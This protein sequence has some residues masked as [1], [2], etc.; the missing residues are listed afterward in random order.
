MLNFDQDQY[1]DD[2]QV[3]NGNFTISSGANDSSAFF[4]M[5]PSDTNNN[6]KQSFGSNSFHSPH[7]TGG[8]G[9][10]S[11]FSNPSRNDQIVTPNAPPPTT[12]TNQGS[13]CSG[14]C[15]A[16]VWSFLCKKATTNFAS[17]GCSA[18]KLA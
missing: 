12:N 16:C 18:P 15:G 10:R 4:N 5:N 14:N 17:I 7:M 9:P 13:K 3:V 8:F 1:N 2:L 11:Y 6:N